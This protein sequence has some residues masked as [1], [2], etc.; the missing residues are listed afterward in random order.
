MALTYDRCLTPEGTAKHTGLPIEPADM[1]QKEQIPHR[2][3]IGARP[4]KGGV[5]QNGIV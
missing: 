4:A 5:A 2:F 3:K 1:Q